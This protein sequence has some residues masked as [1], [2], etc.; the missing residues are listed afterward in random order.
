M[1][2]LDKF[3]KKTDRERLQSKQPAKGVKE[4]KDL[5]LAELKEQKAEGEGVKAIEAKTAKALKEDSKQAYWVLV[6]PLITEKGAYLASANKYIFEVAVCANKIEIK[7]AIQALY[8]VSPIKVNIVNSS[9][10]NVR[11][12]RAFG[13]TKDKKKAIVTLKKGQTIE[14]YEGV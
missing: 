8:G 3:R 1:G 12:G 5:T 14:V 2:L 13:R 10:K 7:K 11:Y 9:G 6:K 4:K